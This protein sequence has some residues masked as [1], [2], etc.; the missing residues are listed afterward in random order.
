MRIIAGQLKSRIF[1]APPDSSHPMSERARGAIFNMLVD[2]KGLVV[3]DAYAGSG[4]L[5]IEA[6]SREQLLPLPLKLTAEPT[7][8]W[9]T[10]LTNWL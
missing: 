9:L 2:V 4:A 6:I 7:E 3:L 10:I 1:K 8:F 5:A